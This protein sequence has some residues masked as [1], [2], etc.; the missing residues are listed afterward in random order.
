LAKHHAKSNTTS[1]KPLRTA[2]GKPGHTGP[3]RV[4]AIWPH[5]NAPLILSAIG[6]QQTV[7]ATSF[8]PVSFETIRNLTLGKNPP[9]PNG[10]TVD[11]LPRWI[12]VLPYQELGS[13]T[14]DNESRGERVL[15]WEI[16]AGLIWDRDSLEPR[17]VTTDDAAHARFHLPVTSALKSILS[18][19]KTYTPQSPNGIHLLPSTSDDTYL[20]TVRR[21]MDDIRR[22]EFYQVN[23][24]RFF[25]ADHAHGWQSLCALMEACAAPQ[26]ALF[27]QG[28]RVISSLSPERFI[29]ITHDPDG[30]CIKTWPIKGT[31][32]RFINDPEKDEQSG[33][34]LSQSEKDRAELRMIIDLMRNDLIQVCESGSVRVAHDAELKKFSH[35][36]HLEGE[37]TGRL[38]PNLKLATLLKAICPGGSITGAP[39]IAAMKR[40]QS[41]EGQPRGYFMGHAFR[42]NYDGSLQSN[43][44]IRTLVSDNWMKTARYA[45]G[46]GIVIKSD[47]QAELEEIRA[48]CAIVTQSPARHDLDFKHKDKAK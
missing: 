32:P 41:D 23:L 48:K 15:A 42:I 33:Q 21:I 45:A 16:F 19:A 8:S 38:Q 44:L 5:H 1:S 30:S 22:G 43:I 20:D 6:G 36:W 47:P 14:N 37:V 3:F 26:A 39:K 31:A 7:I 27:T 12:F 10:A 35:V 28:S 9:H 25:Y 2:K 40:I 46:S 18:E 13:I 34:A 24:L 4:A 11:Q 29:E 17:Y